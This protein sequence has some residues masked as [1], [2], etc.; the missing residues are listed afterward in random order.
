MLLQLTKPKVV[1]YSKTVTIALLL[2]NQILTKPHM[3]QFSRVK[4][5]SDDD[6]AIQQ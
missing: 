4:K 1:V 2:S 5:L 3:S 6:D